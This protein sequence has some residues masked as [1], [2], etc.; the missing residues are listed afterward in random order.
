MTGWSLRDIKYLVPSFVI[1]S[2]ILLVSSLGPRGVTDRT[3]YEMAWWWI[4]YIPLGL[5]LRVIDRRRDGRRNGGAW[6]PVRAI[7]A[8]AWVLFAACNGVVIGTVLAVALRMDFT[9]MMSVG[10]VCCAPVGLVFHRSV[11]SAYRRN[12]D[13]IQAA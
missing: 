5:I 6:T 8:W 1:A 4:G 13:R 7:P 11:H 3:F 10:A 9:V 12:S 2:L